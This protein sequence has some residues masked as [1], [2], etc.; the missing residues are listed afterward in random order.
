MNTKHLW[1]KTPWDIFK[2]FKFVINNLMSLFSYFLGNMVTTWVAKKFVGGRVGAKCFSF[3][4][5][6]FKNAKM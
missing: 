6:Q 3:S 4:L 2:E 1:L 5:Q